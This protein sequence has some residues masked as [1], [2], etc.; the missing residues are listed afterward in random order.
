M[1][2][3]P[4]L[5]IA[6]VGL[7]GF[8]GANARYWL[9]L[10]VNSRAQS[11][12]PYGTLTV[13]IAGSFIL[14]LLTALWLT[15]GGGDPRLKLLIGTGFLGAFTTFSTYMVESVNLMLAGKPSLAL[16]NVLGSVLLGITFAFLGMW[17][18]KGI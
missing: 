11:V 6:L 12:F 4:V 10:W 5:Q 7:G 17:L 15:R 9:G 13:N 16:L 18:G 14:G 2:N 1:M 3:S 8:L